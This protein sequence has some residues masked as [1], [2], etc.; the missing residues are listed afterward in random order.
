MTDV[1]PQDSLRSRLDY[2]PQELRFGTSGRRGRLVHLTQ[3]EIYLNALAEIEYLQSLPPSRGGIRRGEEFYFA[4]DLRPSS[5]RFVAEQ[6]GRGEIA[7]AVERA[8][9]DAGMQPVNLGPIP[10]PALTCFAL[11]RLRGSVMITGSHIPFDWN[12]YKTNSAHGELLKEDESPISERVRLVRQRLYSQRYAES[13]FDGRGHFKGGHRELTPETDEARSAYLERYVGFFERGSL[14]GT[15]VLVYQHSAVGRDLLVEI[16]ER[17]GA[18]V[19]PGG[20]SDEFIAI[21]TENID[22]GLVATIQT[23][24]DPVSDKHSPL[25]AVVSMDG[26]SDRPMV[27]G[28]EPGTGRLKFFGGD[29]LGMIVAEYLEADAVVVPISCNDAIDL[30]NLRNRVAPKT[31]IGSPYVTAGM[32]KARSKGAR[33]VCGWEA[34]GGFIL[35]SDVERGGRVLKALP[36]RDAALPILCALHAARLAGASLAELF[37]RLP[38]RFGRAA[39]LRQVPRVLGRKIVEQ[40]SPADKSVQEVR[41]EEEKTILLDEERREIPSRQSE[42]AEIIR[43]RLALFFPP[44]SGFGKITRL[45]YTDGLRVTFSNGDVAHIRPSGNADELRIYAVADTQARADTIAKMG[46]A[47]PDGLLRK[48]ERSARTE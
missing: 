48:L 19:I 8:I 28:V 17:L 18:G 42:E 45:N 47:E 16:L 35:G 4:Y 36:T 5:T 39:L 43:K 12:G 34:N 31:R 21:D 23:L 27:L 1:I 38:G 32:Q 44:Q 6:Q 40:Y 3:L 7:Q 9:L 37:A 15:R 13:L 41:F 10:T 22:D 29:L 14:Q 33:L 26:D 30:G 20:R 11:S 24:A 46:T 2:E 25:F